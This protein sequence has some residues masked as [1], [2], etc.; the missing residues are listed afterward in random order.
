MSRAD[1]F[2]G[3]IHDGTPT[4]SERITHG[5]RTYITSPEN[6][7][8]SQSTIIFIT[9]AFGF[10][11]VNSK[12]LAD[13]YASRTGFRVL[14]PDIITGGGVPL[15]SLAL[16]ETATAPVAWWDIYGQIRR[17]VTVVRMM[18]I[19]MPFALRTRGVFPSLLAYTR[20]VKAD[21]PAGAKLGAAGFCWGGL[22]TTKL[23]EQPVI[24]GGAEPLIDAHFTAHP[25]GMKP[26]QFLE[27]YQKFRVPLSIAVGDKDFVLSK[28]NVVTI[29]ASFREK[30][31]REAENL[32]YQIKMFEGCGHG[33][34]VRADPGK[35]VE[36]EGALQAIDQAVLW[37]RAFL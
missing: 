21:L 23:T 32:S 36:N 13:V 31:G 29:E 20:A 18:T 9:D 8:S 2:R 28:D 33:F 10:N 27:S 1:C 34:A 37:F 35:T 19:F 4:G 16:M 17:I 11:L 22:Q 12:I 6:A 24:E 5:V 30:Y 3:S 25:A 15:S 14:V 26:P 7:A